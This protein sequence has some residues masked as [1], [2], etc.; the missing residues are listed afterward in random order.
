MNPLQVWAG[1][2]HTDQKIKNPMINKN[3]EGE[4]AF[5]EQGKAVYLLKYD[6]SF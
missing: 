5:R 4:L 6:T 2:L 3:W 1:S